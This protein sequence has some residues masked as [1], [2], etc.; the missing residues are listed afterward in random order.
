[1]RTPSQFKRRNEGRIRRGHLLSM[2]AAAATVFAC[3]V[4]S[5]VALSYYLS[6]D[7]PAT[8]GGADHTP[9]QILRS[10]SATYS[11]ALAFGDPDTQF[12]A[13]HR[14]PDG[15]WL[16]ASATPFFLGTTPVQAH[17]VVSYDGVNFSL[18]FDGSAAGVPHDVRVDAL[19]LDSAG[20]PVFSFDVPVRLGSVEYGPSDLV[21]FSG[22]AFSLYWSAAAAG[23]PAYANVVGADQDNA[24]ALVVS[25][26]VP[27]NL[28]GTEFKPGEL[29]RWQGGTV[30]GSYFADSAWPAT[31]QV[32]DFSFVPPA[33]AVPD[34][35]GTTTPLSVKLAGGNLTLSWGASCAPTDTDY[36]VYEGTL[37]Q[38][39][40]YNHT[41][42]L[43]T[44]SSTTTATFAAPSG[45]AYYLVVPKNALSEGSYGR[46]SSGVEI[47]QGSAAC[48]PQQIAS[49]CP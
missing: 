7:V 47:P 34:G 40:A 43:C 41:Q 48:L 9:D 25:F 21:R 33:G 12:G 32:R 17:D 8:L 18:Y 22:G 35:S 49:A 42:K 5:V 28:G 39:F 37:A 38:P 2:F 20:N 11:I 19:F 31:A 29:V 30:F 13:L 36:E 16:L 27:T 26:D 46:A 4:S 24:G 3:G 6:I 10:D 1:M 23:V 14:R 44:T 45:S 15:V